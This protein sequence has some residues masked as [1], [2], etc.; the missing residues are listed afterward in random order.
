MD[1]SIKPELEQFLRDK[2]ATGQYKTIDEA[3]NQGIEL[4][5][6]REEIYRGRFEELQREIMLG[7]AASEQGQVIEGEVLFERLK[8]KLEQRRE[9]ESDE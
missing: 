4:L 7:V 5:K 9:R 2:I 1:I 8:R 3:I 6:K